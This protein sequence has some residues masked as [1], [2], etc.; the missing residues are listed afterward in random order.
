MLMKVFWYDDGFVYD[1]VTEY[2]ACVRGAMAWVR[3]I[4][5]VQGFT[6]ACI[7]VITRENT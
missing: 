4:V 1:T 7:H 2:C 5:G 6:N 3:N